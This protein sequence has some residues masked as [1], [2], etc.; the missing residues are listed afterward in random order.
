MALI[1]VTRRKHTSALI[2]LILVTAIISGCSSR[3]QII[4]DKNV[5]ESRIYWPQPPDEPRIAYL[6]TIER[7]RDIGAKRGFLYTL[8]A[9][10]FGPSRERIIR[11]YGLAV[12][13][14]GRLVVADTALKGIHIFDGEKGRYKFVNKAGRFSLESIIGVAVDGNDN[15]YVTDSVSGRVYIFNKKGRFTGK[16]DG[17]VRPTGIAINKE[18]ETLYV[19]DTNTHSVSI[20]DLE[21]KLKGTFGGNGFKKGE[22]NYPVTV[23]LD[24]GGD[25][26]ITDSMN[27]RVQI[28]DKD[29]NF[30]TTFGSHGD[31]TGDMA[32]PKGIAIDSDG[33]IYVA[34]AV[35]D[36][37]QVFRRD[38]EFLINFG[39]VGTG[40]GNFWLP[41]GLHMDPFNRLYVADSYNRRVQIFEY[42][43][44]EGAVGHIEAT[45]GAAGSS[46]GG[47]VEE[48]AEVTTEVP[49]I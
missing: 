37:I 7:P 15:I 47:S 23:A 32:R 10:I 25:L 31:G 28:F 39:T 1:I 48:A 6:A 8:G 16:I 34:D 41:S 3:G 40:T 46:N 17:F 9:I 18:S 43:G 5:G 36:T 45:E 11:P 22:F 42:L 49:G 13:S 21:G 38:G 26:Y 20:L 33:N 44:D 14:T 4:G 12:D 35:F 2:L 30:L 27:F 24:R 19:V 29:G